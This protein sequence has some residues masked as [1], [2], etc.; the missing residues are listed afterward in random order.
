MSIDI[1]IKKDLIML[2]EIRTAAIVRL[3]CNENIT[4]DVLVKVCNV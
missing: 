2:P 1:E 3:G 4:A